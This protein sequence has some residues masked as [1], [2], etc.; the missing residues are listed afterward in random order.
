MKTAISRQTQ[1]FIECLID[2][3]RLYTKVADAIGE[4]YVKSQVDSIINE[5]YFENHLKLKTVIQE[6]LCDLIDDNLHDNSNEI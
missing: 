1:N 6:F 2:L 3:D 5:R 4:V